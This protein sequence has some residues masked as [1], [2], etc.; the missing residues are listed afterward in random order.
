MATRIQ[1]RR[2]TAANWSSANPTLAQGELGLNLDTNQIKIG[3]GLTAWNSLSYTN[4]ALDIN[5]LD[6][7][8][9][10]DAQNG[11]FLRYNSSAS[12]W[13][14]DP[15]NL[16][17]DTVGD[18]VQSLTA[19]TG[20]NLTNNSGEGSTPTIAIGQAVGTSSSV[21]F[22]NVTADLIGDVTGNADTAT[23]LE[24]ARTIQLS[25]DVSGSVS[26]DGTANINLVTTVNTASV[27][28]GELYGVNITNPEEFQSLSYNGTQWVNGHIPVVS[29]VQNAEATTLTTGTVVYL[30]GGTGD[31][32]SVK[33]ADNNS[34]TTSSK[35]VGV[36]AA[37]IAASQ[38]GPVVT[39]GYVDGINLSTYSVGDI[40][41]L[42]ANG[43]FSTTKPVAPKHMV[44]VGVVVRATNN[45]IMY[46]ATQ[47]GYE[48]EE[49]HD[50]KISGVTDGQFLRYN[51]ASTIWVNDTINLGTDTAGSYVES[52]VAGTGVTLTNNSGEGATPTVAIGQAV[53]TSSSVTFAKVDTT[54]D[55]TVGGN[56]TVNGTT[57]TLNTET[58]AVEDNIVVLNS[59]FT[60]SPTLN[61]GIEVERG[62]STNVV[63]R[64]NET[65]DQWETTENGSTFHSIINT[66]SLED[67]LAQEHWHKAARLATNGVLPNSPTYTAGTLDEDGGY[68]IGAKLE[69][70]TNAALVVDSTNAAQYDRILVKNQADARQNGVYEVTQ[71]GGI[72][73][74]WILI[75]ANDMDGSSNAQITHGETIAVAAGSINVFQTFSIT[76]FGSGT[77][78]AHVIGTDDIDYTQVT[79]VAQINFG[80]GLTV[81]Q[82]TVTQS[83]V[84]TSAST[85][86]TASTFVNSLIVDE[87]GR[88]T[89][90]NSAGVQIPLGTSTSGDY[91]QS[92]VAG[93]G[94]TLSNNSGES[95]TPT[96]A[97]GQDV[98]ISASVDFERVYAQEIVGTLI[99]G[100]AL[101]GPLTGNASTATT[102]QNSR[103]IGLSGDV[104][105][106][107]SFN[108]SSDITITATIQANSVTLGTDTTGNYMSDLTQGTGV[109]IT[110]TPGEGSNATIAIGQSV[111][112][113]NTPTF[114][115]LNLNGNITFEGTS[116]NEFE[117]TL[118]VTDPTADN[119]ITLP[120]V[121]GTVVTT[122]DTG[123]VT[124]AMIAD[125]TIANGD[126]SATA[127]IDKTKISGTA[128]TAGDTGTVTST[129]IADGT[130]VNGDINASAGIALSKL[131][132]STAGNI[133]VYNASGVPT[134]VAE[135]GDV[136]I[137]DTGVTAIASGVIVDADIN[138]SAAISLS[139]LATG[140]LPS[141]ITVASA[142]ITDLSIVNAD[143]N[144]SA[145][146]EL[147]KLATSTAGNIIVYN[148]SGVP[149]AV[150]E[151][152]DV[153]ISDTGVTAISSGVIVDADINAS[154]AITHSKLANIT[155]GSVLMGNATNVPTA[156]VLSGDVTVGSTGV[157]AIGT[158]VIVNADINA[159]AGIELSKLATSTAGNIIVYNASGVPTSV[160]ET[161]DVTISDTG[162]TAISSGVIVNAD[163]NASAAIDKTKISGTA[164][165][166]ADTGT[167]TSTMISDGT[168]VNGDINAAAA[169]A[170][171]KL[172]SGTSGQIIVANS[173]GVPTWVSETG[174][175]TISDTGVTAI[176]SGVIV[177][178]DINASAAIAHSKLA[179]GTAGQVLLGT[180]TTGVITATTI[181][182]DITING[183]GVASIAANSVALGTDTTGDYVSSLVAGT[184]VTLTNNSGESAT[185]TVAIGQEVAT[186]SSVTFAQLTTTGNVVIGGNLNVSGSVT[187]VNQTSLAIDDPLIYMN[188]GSTVTDPDLGF[189]GNYNDGTY[190]HAGLF[191]DASDSHTFK[192]FKGL[193]VEPTAPINTAHGSYTP[194]DVSANT[195]VSTV[196]TGT[197]PLSVSSSTVV[198]NLNAD[199]LD[200]QH[201]SYYAPLASPT[202][203]GTV[204]L[205]TGTVTSGMILDG[206]IANADINASAAIEHSKLANATAGQVLLG[207]TTTGVV[208]ATTV[209]GDVTI[210]GA[211]VTSIGSGVI[212]NA[213]VNA[214][215][216]IALSKLAT[217]TAGTVVLH[218]AS[219]VPTATAVS[220]DITISDTGVTAI[221]SGVIVNADINASAAIDKTK[222]SGT[223]ITAADSGTVT[224]T[225]IADGT[226]V[227]ADINAA[228]AIAHSKLANATAGQV[229]LGTTTTGVVTA[230]TV[231]GDVTITGGG[232][233]AIG[234]G[235]IVNADVNASAAI[236]YSKLAALTSGN[237]LVGNASNV[238]TSVAVTGDVTI[239]NAGV[240]AIGSG[241][242]VNA[243]INA[244]AAIDKTKISGTAVTVA[245]TGTVTS[246]MIADA[247]IVNGDIST[248]AAIAHSKL[249][250]ATAGQ[251]LLGTT[252]T[253]VVTATTVSGDVTITGAGVT[254][255]GSGVIVNADI[256][257][258]AAIELSKLA[259]ST[260]GNIIVYNSSGVPTAVAETGDVTISD[261]GVT[262]IASGVIVNADISATA[263]IDLGKL[264]DVSTNAQ[265]ASYTLVL[266]DKNKVVEMGVASANNLTV[267]LNSSVA[268]PVGSQI[269]IL[270]TGA[271]QTTIVATGGVTINATPGLKMRAQ[272][273]YATLIKR[274]TDT[275]VLVGDISA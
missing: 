186:S 114:A 177:D 189:A 173:S 275:W 82:N 236:D 3:N 262:A 126:I 255:I 179:N 180:T 212:V 195:Y 273:S 124:S 58:L 175:V 117:T 239:T 74:H 14:N 196:A 254:A 244:S 246:A 131:A 30:F 166:A 232:V 77:G 228:A 202:F 265:T 199:L 171:S 65:T 163:I 178:A 119:T 169:I 187:T 121:T 152:G 190:R 223:A 242:I 229:L 9:I 224:S 29:Y 146:I 66:E 2:D 27:A 43:L 167:V 84:N 87:F 60:G 46:V 222:I 10:T 230:T 164:I 184:G 193:T 271:G 99:N 17:T 260:A 70:S 11:D 210:T 159:S 102:L 258:S 158:G 250:N 221:G 143:V 47:N 13:I 183:A 55:V 261:T 26:F 109:T 181:S 227:N 132:T 94:V 40:L 161:G 148:S 203:T 243:D 140:A 19:G 154:A 231:S 18:Y 57:T 52:L 72:G 204:T 67:R 137:S 156:T 160:A 185:P 91:V 139:K 155:A 219:G 241:V 257:A 51:S 105:G 75:R 45:G 108:G 112:T 253:G 48:L 263:A 123:T 134:S 188:S 116:A 270:Q 207:T 252:T 205:P 103:T 35:T 247:T 115:G 215:A 245:D 113:S 235:V 217:G 135:T 93:T 264:A 24:T 33:R 39:R 63:L 42:N 198:T 176:S 174:D 32:A 95:A 90:Y 138:A 226:I 86:G 200:G 157:T 80:S 237:I 100:V 120:N 191:S 147:S 218:N 64:W 209:S 21:T 28:I 267:P 12:A 76:S 85:S 4:L 249:A 20:V 128:I 145:A 170:L 88:L 110:H 197:A 144:A 172:A 162:V 96:I 269:N 59:N 81:S 142:N 122:G 168:I 234:S 165:T 268:F 149:T 106:S 211:G 38:N 54:G 56:L 213:D 151:T 78:A 136:T 62:D 36:V 44:F 16:S 22:A 240:T 274:A 129:M 206:T 68:G 125:G 214:S 272:W 23:A 5:D 182:G 220:G 104:S 37:P 31:H 79:G 266:A 97:I 127:A 130:I 192:F 248:T 233:T 256:N 6:G 150:A 216:A 225:M 133:I 208:T 41:W 34:D 89:G 111:A 1:L 251:V 71:A 61:A 25:G 194:A 153:T 101:V 50:V 118:S 107:A 7:V 98:S 259:T 201:G 8:T 92:L 141:T 238:A 49:L 15:V 83:L 73:S 69:S 53:G